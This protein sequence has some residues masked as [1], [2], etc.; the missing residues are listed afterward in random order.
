[1]LFFG[2]LV[3]GSWSVAR[4]KKKKKS[5]VKKLEFLDSDDTAEFLIHIVQTHVPFLFL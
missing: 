5:K 3:D 4:S 2:V 1:M